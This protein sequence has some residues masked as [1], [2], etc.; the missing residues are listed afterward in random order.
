M[1]HPLQSLD[2]FCTVSFIINTLFPLLYDCM[3]TAQT[4]SLQIQGT[5]YI[6]F[7]VIFA[8]KT[9]SLE[10]ILQEVKQME[11]REQ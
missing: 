7:Q 5:S 1:V 4:S 3:P 10:W 9:A 8:C 2:Y 11:V 6:E